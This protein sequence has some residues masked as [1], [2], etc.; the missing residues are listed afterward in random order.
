MLSTTNSIPGFRQERLLGLAQGI[1]VRSRNVLRD[2]AAGAKQ[3]FQG[4]E[5][6]TWTELCEASREEALQRLLKN[7]AELGAKGVVAL[8]YETEEIAPQITEVFAYGTA[9]A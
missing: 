1:T 6:K 5:I 9:I 8:R 4:G 3:F 7:A 2:I